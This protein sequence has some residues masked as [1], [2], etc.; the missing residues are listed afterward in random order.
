MKKLFSILMGGFLLFGCASKRL[1][2]EPVSIKSDYNASWQFS[3]GI[4]ELDTLLAAALKNNED[5]GV[6]S[7]NLRQAMLRAGLVA[8]DLAPT[9]SASTGA[10]STKD[11]KG[12][13]ASRAFSSELALSWELDIFGRIYDSYESSKALVLSSEFSLKDLQ[14]VILNSVILQYFNAIYLNENKQNLEK[15]YI[16]MLKLHELIANK[17]SLGKEE[18]LALAQSS[19]NLLSLQNS[20]NNADKELQNSFESLKNLTGIE[21]KPSKLISEIKAPVYDTG[22]KIFDEN[23]TFSWI[24]RI[25]NRPDINRALAQL[26]AGFYDYSAASKDFLP[27]ISVGGSLSDRDEKSSK[28]FGFNLLSGNL[29]ITLPFLDY[30]RLKQNLKISEVEFLKLKLSYEQALRA[31]INESIKYAYLCFLDEINIT[32]QEQIVLQREK[33]LAIYEQKYNYG[34][35]E[36]SDLLNAQNDLLNAQNTLANM[37]YQLLGDI[38]GFFKA[39]AY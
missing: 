19:Q 38:I 10:S 31:A 2:Y 35:K 29:R 26:N 17:V 32:N 39:T 9:L 25:K 3:F 16:N 27:R 33:I 14:I 21:L 23:I 36:F 4:D 20:L 30:Y 5:L 34:R 18:P 1:D 6:A 8:S 22:I 7:L 37:K 11:L 28:A 15:N 13:P 24:E 12:G